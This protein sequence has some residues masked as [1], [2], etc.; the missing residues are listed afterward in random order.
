MTIGNDPSPP[1]PPTL[2]FCSISLF[3]FRISCYFHQPNSDSAKSCFGLTWGCG[4]VRSSPSL[5]W[6]DDR[7]HHER[8]CPSAGQSKPC[9]VQLD[10]HIR[11]LIFISPTSSQMQLS[12]PAGSARPL[13][14]KTPLVS[15]SHQPMIYN[16]FRQLAVCEV[17]RRKM[18]RQL[19]DCNR[20][21]GLF[22]RVFELWE[23]NLFPIHVSKAPFT[24]IVALFSNAM[25]FMH[26][27]STVVMQ[28]LKFSLRILTLLALTFPQT[29]FC[30]ILAR[31][32][33]GLF[34]S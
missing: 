7:T 6:A 9:I 33:F 26:C 29:P 3:L 4:T 14:S 1:H 19:C 23:D 12:R 28:S 5:W 13:L 11:S 8:A 16:P 20:G 24:S 2:R 10:F 22:W 27:R 18:N 30:V 17:H 15:V 25:N 31:F 21:Q 32:A 34:S